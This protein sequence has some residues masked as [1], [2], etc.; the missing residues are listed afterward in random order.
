MPSLHLV[1]LS[2]PSNLYNHVYL[3]MQIYCLNTLTSFFPSSFLSGRVALVYLVCCYCP[4]KCLQESSNCIYDWKCHSSLRINAYGWSSCLTLKLCFLF[5]LEHI[6]KHGLPIETELPKFS[7]LWASL[8][9]TLPLPHI[10]I[11]WGRCRE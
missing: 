5:N 4:G 10:A 11:F 2:H 8:W 1:M 6:S 3:S 9:M 7:L